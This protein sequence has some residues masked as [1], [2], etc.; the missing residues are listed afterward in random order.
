MT[1]A[2][3]FILGKLFLEKAPLYL[4]LHERDKF[5]CPVVTLSGKDNQK[6]SKLVKKGFI[7]SLCW[8]EYETKQ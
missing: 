6:L 2:P 4:G 5:I 3:Y 8:N 1:Y 7:G